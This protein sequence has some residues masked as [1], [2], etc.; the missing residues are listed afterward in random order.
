MTLSQSHRKVIQYIFPDLY[1]LCPKYLSE[2]QVVLTS[3]AKVIAAAVDA[4]TDADAATE[5]N[6]KH[7]DWGDLINNR[8]GSGHMN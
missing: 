1:F 4:D 6:W 5:T 3:E 2:A 7:K 8:K